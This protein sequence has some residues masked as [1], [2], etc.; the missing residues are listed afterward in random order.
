FYRPPEDSEEMRYMRKR[1]EELGGFL[2]ARRTN[3]TSLEVPGLEAFDRLLKGSGEREISTTMVYVRILQ[4]LIRDKKI[5]ERVVP[6]VPDEA[7]TF[8][9]EGLF[10]SIGLYSARGQLYTPPDSDQLAW[11]RES[12]DGQIL[13]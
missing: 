4:T 12:T 11:Y 10:R 1:R 7:R 6:I 9:M 2:P 8:G 13:E 3:S 5:G